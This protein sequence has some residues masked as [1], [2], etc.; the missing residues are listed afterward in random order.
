MKQALRVL[1]ADQPP[2]IVLT[3]VRKCML[4]DAG[5]VCAADQTREGS[6]SW[7]AAVQSAG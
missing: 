1:P 6:R 5:L 7:Q 2:V 4:S 3:K